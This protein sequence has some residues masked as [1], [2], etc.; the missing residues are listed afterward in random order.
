MS[1]PPVREPL[2]IGTW[3]DEDRYQIGEV[4]GQGSFS[5]TYAARE[6]GWRLP[7]AIKE[8]FPLGCRRDG[9]AI[10]ADS[11]WDEKS[12]ESSLEAFLQEGAMLERFHHPGIVRVLSKFRSHQTACLVEELLEGVT[13]G[14]GLQLVGAMPCS[15]A[16]QMAQQVG[17]ALLQVHAAGLVHSDIKPD[18][19]FLCNDGRYV[20][21]D[22]GTARGYLSQ[23]KVGQAAVSLGYSPPEQYE[24]QQKLTPAA[25]VYALAATVFHLLAGQ[26][27]PDARL[28]LKGEPLL[29]LPELPAGLAAGLEAG[30]ALQAAQRTQAM[31]AFL[32]GIGVDSSPHASLA[33]LNSFEALGQQMAHPGGVRVLALHAATSRLFS[34]GR[35]GQWRSWNWP[36]LKPLRTQPAHEAPINALAVSA[37]GQFLVTGGADGSAKLWSSGQEGAPHCLLE[38]GP[39]ILSLAFHPHLGLVAASMGNGN[40][41]LMGPM[42]PNPLCWAAHQGAVN[43]LALH[44]GGDLLA[45]AGDDKAIH[46]WTLPDCHY[47]GSLLRHATRLQSLT[48]TRNGEGLLTSSS[49]LSV[50]L[51]D[52]N[53]QREIRI[54]RGH[55]ALVWSVQ[56]T[57]FPNLVVT[58]SA[59]RWLRGFRLDAGLLVLQVEAHEGWVR[60]LAVDPVG[61]YLATG[62]ADGKICLWGI[63]GQA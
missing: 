47:Q 17:Q 9:G 33:H 44:P 55:R 31:R 19:L 53:A 45:T 59:D 18:N 58:V 36:D 16:L 25:D 56:E 4:V 29:G 8:F 41:C 3:L 14:Q 13:L 49:D 48:Y 26:P 46:T 62:G 2:P 63:P 38:G 51:W 52:L 32:A 57:C 27:P 50:R 6:G 54:L 22:F 1:N 24:L 43:G 30:L 28:R 37:D 20:I 23:G 40:C 61:P 10:V 34:A 42:A 11:P 15:R 7:V 39:A 12:F 60:G 35:D 5:L 21:L